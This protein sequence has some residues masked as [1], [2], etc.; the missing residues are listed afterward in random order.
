M[1]IMLPQPV[2]LVCWLQHLCMLLLGEAMPAWPQA[3]AAQVHLSLASMMDWKT[4]GL[5]PTWR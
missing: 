2:C 1:R 5:V 3:Y 4:L